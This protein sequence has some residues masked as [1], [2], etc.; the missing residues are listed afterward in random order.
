MDFLGYVENKKRIVIKDKNISVN[1]EFGKIEREVLINS[2]HGDVVETS[3]GK[4]V[5]LLEPNFF[6][7]YQSMK[8]GA[9]SIKLKDCATILS[10]TLVGKN[11]I[12]LDCGAGMGGLSCFLAR[13]VKK[14]YSV[15]YVKKHLENSEKNAK[16][17]GLKNI[18]F[19]EADIYEKIPVKTKLDLITLDIINPEKIVV[20]A[21]KKLKKGGS[22][23]AY[24]PQAT[25]MQVFVQALTENEF[26]FIK[27]FE[28]IK[29]SWK[30]EGKILRP[31]H[32]GLM[33]TGFLVFGRR[34]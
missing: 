3:K 2:K 20:E 31:E 34:I 24:C 32:I 11:S 6:D 25:Q 10:E 22:I 8:R 19:I 28:I 23:V 30:V 18:K 21:K 1:T 4:K 13:Y 9:Q 26:Q 29:R 12:C 5:T 27:S 15:D 14:V 33:H 17:L 7:K 16:M